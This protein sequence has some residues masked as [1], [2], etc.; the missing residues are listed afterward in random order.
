MDEINKLQ[1]I[2][3]KEISKK[4]H[5]E[6]RTLEF[7]VNKEFDRLGKIN[8]LG[9]LKIISREYNVDLQDWQSEFEE[10]LESKKLENQDDKNSNFFLVNKPNRGSF[11]WPIIILLLILLGGGFWY[12]NGWSYVKPIFTSDKHPKD[13]IV[14]SV[15]IDEAK[16]NLYNEEENSNTNFVQEVQVDE[17]SIIEHSFNLENDKELEAVNF[18]AK[19]IVDEELASVDSDVKVDEEPKEEDL[20]KEPQESSKIALEAEKATIIP[21]VKLWVGAIFLEDKKRASYLS[22]EA[23]ELDFSKDQLIT[24]GHGNF[25]LKIGDMEY[26]YAKEAPKR[27]YWKDGELKEISYQE[28]LELNGGSSW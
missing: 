5:I 26:S 13:P 4:T 15:A 28:F 7:I 17:D 27:F 8:T 3:L 2:G 19:N 10:Y 21:N 1:E 14:K 22:D 18:D 24:T 6:V 23:I 25:T 16:R 20:A 12:F 9:F 11:K